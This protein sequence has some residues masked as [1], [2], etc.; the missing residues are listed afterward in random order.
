[1]LTAL[2]DK[3]QLPGQWIHELNSSG[4][5]TPVQ[6]VLSGLGPCRELYQSD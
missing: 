5:P 4:L 2:E 1:M 3:A 6:G